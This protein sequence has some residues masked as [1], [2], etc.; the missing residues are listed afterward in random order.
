MKPGFFLKEAL[1]SI[2]SNV[3]IAVAATVTVM[4]AV[5]IL[6][7]FIPSFLY[8]QSKVDDQKE[9]LLVNAYISDS[10]TDRQVAGLKANIESLQDRGLVESFT[11]VSKDD[12]LR[13]LR[14][15]LD[16]PDEI[17]DLLPGNPL[18]ASYTI[19][20][21]DPERNDEIAA[22]LRDS[23]AL[24]RTMDGGGVSYAEETSEKLLQ[25]ATII[26]WV[27]LALI[28]ILMLSSVLLIGNTIR[29]SIYARRREVEVMRLVGA[30]NW[31]IR[32]P[33]VI[34]GIICGVVGAVISLAFLWAGKVTVVDQLLSSNGL[35][36]DTAATIGFVWLG[37]LL[38]AAGG[39]VGALGSGITLRRFLRV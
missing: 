3:A 24:D 18:P 5:F 17:L 2:R 19:D 31:F 14:E 36:K 38:V 39:L 25:W 9:R 10:A 34:E 23:P 8:V 33:F 1:R 7:V 21:V 37:L 16:N 4:I 11:Y 20:P 30:T 29:L 32:W 28:V 15:R 12:A 26:Q 22:A 35:E 27:T 13:S 6:G